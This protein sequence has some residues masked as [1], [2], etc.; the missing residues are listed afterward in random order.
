MN[1]ARTPNT[2][3]TVYFNMIKINT[4]LY[5]MYCNIAGQP[6]VFSLLKHIIIHPQSCS[7]NNQ[8]NSL[9]NKHHPML[10]RERKSNIANTCEKLTKGEAKDHQYGNAEIICKY[11]RNDWNKILIANSL[12]LIQRLNN[13]TAGE[14]YGI[15]QHNP[16][17]ITARRLTMYYNTIS[18]T[19]I[20]ITVDEIL[21]MSW[22]Q[23]NFLAWKHHVN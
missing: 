11:L 17:E 18:W 1:N 12:L 5:H 10:S 22:S 2:T 3:S 9:S 23:N 20:A 15:K 4:S 14:D 19:H 13:H 16:K 8:I 7:W 6:C 21:F